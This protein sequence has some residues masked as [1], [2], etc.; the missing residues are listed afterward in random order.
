MTLT[1]RIDKEPATSCI[2]VNS[3]EEIADFLW[4]MEV[5]SDRLDERMLGF[6]RESY[7]EFMAMPLKIEA[8]L[9]RYRVEGISHLVIVGVE[10]QY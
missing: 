10:N 1:Y 4:T 7:Q 8:R 5:G 6:W 9:S 3:F 2:I